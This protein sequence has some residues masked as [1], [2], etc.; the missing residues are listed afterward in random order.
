MKR[1]IAIVMAAGAVGY[2][3]SG[4]Y[5][6][7]PSQRGVQTFLG[8]PG[9]VP[10]TPGLHIHAPWPLGGVKLVDVS[11]VRSLN[12]KF[13]WPYEPGH[14][15]YLLTGDENVVELEVQVHYVVDDPITYTYADQTPQDHLVMAVQ[16][17][18]VGILA[19]MSVDEALTIGRPVI[20]AGLKS[21]LGP[22]LARR[23]GV[24]VTS[25]LITR[26]TPPVQVRSAF[27]AVASAKADQA[28][29]INDAYGDRN[30]RL[31]R[32]RADA[33]RKVSTAKAKA[34]E[35]LDKTRGTVTAFMETLGRYKAAPDL[36]MLSM[37]AERLPEALKKVKIIIVDPTK[38]GDI[39]IGDA[40]PGVKNSGKK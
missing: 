22:V 24:K 27:A 8:R 25:V 38:V 34:R 7:G 10:T 32:A 16:A 14:K 28:R 13:E 23:L 6:V 17:E 40:P 39:F 21:R 5:S 1:W 15:C 19:G 30:R 20:A 11:R 2:L 35:L 31:P 4:I 36:T 37:L 12:V 33:L 26:L 29:R 18:A 3:V 9:K